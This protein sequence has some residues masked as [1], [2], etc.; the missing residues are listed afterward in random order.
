MTMKT[1]PSFLTASMLFAGSLHAADDLVLTRDGT[2]D[3]VIV[4]PRGASPATGR[5]G[6]ELAQHLKLM[7]GADFRIIDDSSPAPAHAILLGVA[8]PGERLD[9]GPNTDLGADGFVIRTVGERVYVAGP[10]ARGTMYGCS[11][12]LESLGVRWFTPTVT[13]APARPTITLAPINARE[14]PAFEYRE[15]FFA[16]AFNK[17]WAARLRLNGNTPALDESTGGKVAYAE[18]VHTFDS[19]IPQGLFETH[20]EYFPLIDAKRT[21]GYVQRCLTNPDVLALAIAGVKRAFAA[22]PDAVIMSVSQNDCASWCQCDACKAITEKYGAHSGLYLWFV[23]QVA[24]AI[25]KDHPGKLIDTLAYQFTEA[26]PKGI[27][28]RDNVRVRLCPIAVCEAHPYERCDFPATRE[29]VANLHAWSTITSTLY[30]WHYN[31]DF[32]NYLMPFPDFDEF[33]ADL[34][35][36]QKSGVKGVFFQ[37]AYA[38]GGGGSD[39][40]LRSYVMAKILWNP[41]LDADALVSEWMQGVYGPAWKPLREWFDLLHQRARVPQNHLRIYDPPS[42]AFFPPEV[43]AA[44]DKLF[45]EAMK[46]ATNDQQRRDVSRARM[47]LRYVKLVMEPRDDKVLDAFLT[48]A[49]AFGITSLNEGGTLESWAGWYHSR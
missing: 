38:P 6:Q 47:W 37:G 5:G 15:P 23:N 3:Y 25:E 11:A 42:D 9:A 10:G 31:T 48:D 35:L 8:P 26:P 46:L 40:E 13:S 27:V 33:P 16:E 24:E 19:L 41:A 7:S 18:F 17:D 49:R 14:V 20:P 30:I 45:D 12:L 32:A 1:A 44:G 28:P 2:T 34:R 43:R 4:V 22:R 36:Y 21:G 29:F 39:G